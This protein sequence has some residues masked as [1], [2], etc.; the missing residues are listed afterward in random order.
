MLSLCSVTLMIIHQ[1]VN[2]F[3]LQVK[4]AFINKLFMISMYFFQF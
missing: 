4:L 1:V 3:Q 2:R